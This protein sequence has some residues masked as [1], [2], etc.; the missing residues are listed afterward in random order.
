MLGVAVP[1]HA[2][3]RGISARFVDTWA[4]RGEPIIIE[5][6][7]EDQIGVVDHVEFELSI[8][9][10]RVRTATVASAPWSATFA[11]EAVWPFDP[12]RLEVRARL[13]GR[14]GGLLLGLGVPFGYSLEIL[15][16][17]QSA[18]RRRDFAPP[19]EEGP[20]PVVVVLAAE[21]RA[22]SA[23]RTRAHVAVL[24][25]VHPRAQLKLALSVGPSFAE[26]DVLAGGGPLVLG[27]ELGA[28]FLATRRAFVDAV[29]TADLRFPGFD[30]GGAVF[31]GLH[32]PWGGIGWEV[33]A[34]GGA[35]AANATDDVDA[36][37]FGAVRA[38]VRFG[39]TPT[40]SDATTDP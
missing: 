21:A 15:E 22:G 34:G 8:D 5:A 4:T 25:P 16:P 12:E 32:G 19:P 28:R 39:S 24:G 2:F 3:A 7:I 23:S 20:F 38:G 29:A 37:F 14:R 27:A 30:P 10:R 35:L 9:D 40:G 26:P 36:V 1:N 13:F 33:S 17:A 18:Q 6:R 11:S 31:V